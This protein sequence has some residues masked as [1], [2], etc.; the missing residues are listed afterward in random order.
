MIKYLSKVV[1][2]WAVALLAAA[3][4]AAHE[5]NAAVTSILFNPRTES[6]EVMH[7]FSLHDAEHAVKR[8]F[9]KKADIFKSPTT[10]QQFADYVQRHFAIRIQDEQQI[11]LKAVGHEIDGKYFWVYQEVAMP[12]KLTHLMV[13]HDVLREIWPAQINTVNIEGHGKLQTLTFSDNAS[14]LGLAISL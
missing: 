3:P 11:P 7:R 13:K 2:V 1:L 5:I 14:W 10:Q 8:L 6:I 12:E 4:L 9:E